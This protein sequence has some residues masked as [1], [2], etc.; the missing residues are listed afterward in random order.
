M[1]QS[2]FLNINGHYFLLKFHINYLIKDLRS[3]ISLHAGITC[4]EI[5]LIYCSKELHD[6]QYLNHFDMGIPLQVAKSGEKWRK[7]AKN[8]EK[9]RNESL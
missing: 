1:I 4:Q 3:V 2:I 5:R 6:N 7:V 9:W 8:G